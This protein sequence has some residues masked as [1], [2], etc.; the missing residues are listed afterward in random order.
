MNLKICELI[1]IVFSA[2]VGGMYWGPW[3]ALSR[4]MRTFKPEVFLD[5]VDRMNRNM[6]S[7]MTVLT[8]VGL[9][10]IA[11]VLFFSYNEQPMTF[12]LTLAGFTL[13][14]FALVVT[15]LIEVPIVKQIVTWKIEALP[16]H[17]QQLRDRW[18]AFHIIRVVA[19]IGGLVFLVAGA[20]FG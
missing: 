18:V 10:A 20:I 1:S 17:W 13:F 7:V 19:G 6:E 4:S 8:P 12:Y 11:P 14:L 5:I 9:I 3:L 2:L 16:S 15:M